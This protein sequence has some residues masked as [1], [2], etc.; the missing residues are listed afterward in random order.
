LLSALLRG[1]TYQ[2]DGVAFLV[3]KKRAVLGDDMGLGKTRQAIVAMESAVP[4]GPVLVV[5]PASLKLN[6]RRGILLLDKGARISSAGVFFALS[7]D[8]PAPVVCKTSQPIGTNRQ[9]G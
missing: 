3:S 9:D 6:W 5:C 7:P 2:A 8:E 1:R 4:E